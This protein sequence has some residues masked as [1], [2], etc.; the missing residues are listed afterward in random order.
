MKKF[1]LIYGLVLVSLFISCTK[2]D[3][4]QYYS[5]LGTVSKTNDS[6]IIVTDESERLLVKNTGSTIESLKDKDRVIAYF[7]ITND[8]LPKGINYVVDLYDITKVLYKPAIDLTP[9]NADSIGN[10]PI[11]VN[12]I[13]VVRD[14]LN[15]NF[16]YYGNNKTH[17]INLVRLPATV[18]GDTINLEV[19]HNDNGDDN[20]YEING[21]VS[22]DLKSLQKAAADS[23]ILHVKVK[24]FA[25]NF[26]EHYFTYKY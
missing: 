18:T 15:M 16:T 1:G 23:V 10:D 25:S 5:V 2:S 21:L 13:W 26:Y 11:N 7:T 24:E 8:M 14:Y 20:S 9:E 19:R 4:K 6:T 22:F 3:N 12:N 17:Y